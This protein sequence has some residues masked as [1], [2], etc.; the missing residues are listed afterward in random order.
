MS[1]EATHETSKPAL[2]S[3]NTGLVYDQHYYKVGGYINDYALTFDPDYKDEDGNKKRTVNDFEDGT[4]YA[5][6]DGN[7]FIFRKE[8]SK[9]DLIPWFTVEQTS[10]MTPKLVY[11]TRVSNTTKSAFTLTSI[12]DHYTDHILNDPVAREFKNDESMHEEFMRGRSAYTPEIKDDDDFLKKT[13]KKCL[14]ESKAN[15]KEFEKYSDKP[16]EIPNLIQTLNGKTKLSPKFFQSWM[17]YGGWEYTVTVRNGRGCKNPLPAEI[18][19]DSETNDVYV[20]GEDNDDESKIVAVHQ[21]G[22]TD[23]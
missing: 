5:D 20:K 4:G 1:E 11:T 2:D 18:V 7:I 15:A 21:F 3:A 19:Y 6:E 12:I 10:E 8:P 23:D 17:G 14:I 16:W 9:D 22:D 13:V